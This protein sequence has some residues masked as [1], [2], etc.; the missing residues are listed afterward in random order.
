MLVQPLGNSTFTLPLYKIK[1]EVICE[2]GS[3][4]K[5]VDI[6]AGDAE[7][8]VAVDSRSDTSDTNCDAVGRNI[9]G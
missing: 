8:G 3:G 5:F 9:A 7:T 2:G 4:S 1:R 6:N